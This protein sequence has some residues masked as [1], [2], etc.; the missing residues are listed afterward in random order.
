MA[1]AVRI[2]VPDDLAQE[3]TRD[4]LSEVKR[5]RGVDAQTILTIAGTAVGVA[6]NLVTILVAQD[7]IDTFT[8]TLR[9][10]IGRR[11]GRES[12]SEFTLEASRND[13]HTEIKVR[14]VSRRDDANQ[15]PQVDV[16][17]VESLIRAIFTDSAASEHNLAD[18]KL[19][20]R[21]ARRLPISDR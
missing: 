16:A 8:R 18:P 21:S 1:D 5:V 7:Q 12:G 4:G 14:I 20:Q 11:I 19:R 15:P 10:W 3:L 6:A 9:R 2:A 13:G 17:A